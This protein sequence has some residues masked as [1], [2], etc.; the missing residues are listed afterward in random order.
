VLFDF[1]D[2]LFGDC[3]TQ[4]IRLAWGVACQLHGGDH[5]LLLVDRVPISL[6][7]DGLQLFVLVGH[8]L[9]AVHVG[10][11]FRNAFHWTRSEE[12]YHGNHMM[13]GLGLHLHQVAGHAVAF[14]LEETNRVTFADELVNLRVVNGDVAEC[15][16]NA[17][18]LSDVFAGFRHDRE[19]HQPQEIHLEQTEVVDAVHVVL[20]HG[21][22]RQLIAAACRSV[23][24][25]VFRERF[26]TDD[27]AGGMRAHVAQASFHPPGG[28]EQ[29]L[30][31][32]GR[33][34]HCP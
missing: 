14:Q 29:V 12:R 3:R 9:F 33:F 16:L 28:I 31:L 23:Q 4:V 15:Q 22:D 8:W 5:D 6:T 7:Q 32:I 34:I 13:D 27:H 26:I 20:R 18:T 24:R 25:E 10:D 21:F 11:V 2:L 17:V 30:H 1:L 19:R